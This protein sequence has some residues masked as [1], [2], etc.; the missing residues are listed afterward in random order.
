MARGG[1][2]EL[3]RHALY[4]AGWCAAIRASTYVMQAIFGASEEA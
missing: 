1:D 4:L 2:D 3:R